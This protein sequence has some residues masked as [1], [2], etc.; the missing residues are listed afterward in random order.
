MKFKEMSWKQL[1]KE[2]E[3][4]LTNFSD[5][6]LVESIRKYSI[7]NNEYVYENSNNNVEECPNVYLKKESAKIL[8]N[9]EH[10][11]IEIDENIDL[12]CAA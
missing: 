5:E 9:Y 12:G 11:N 4:I 10:N 2:F 1:Q 3:N 6:Q 8:V 7:N